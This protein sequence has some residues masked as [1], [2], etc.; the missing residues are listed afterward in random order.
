MIATVVDVTLSSALDVEEIIIKKE[1]MTVMTVV[2]M[3][4]VTFMRNPTQL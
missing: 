3:V 1:D 4:I 2:N